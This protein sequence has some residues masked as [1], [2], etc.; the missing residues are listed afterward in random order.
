MEQS[1][2]LD[3]RDNPPP[4]EICLPANY[5]FLEIMGKGCYGVVAKC[6]KEDSKETVAV[7]VS[8]YTENAKTE[9]VM[10]QNLMSQGLDEHNIVRFHESF[11]TDE[12]N[13]LVFE[14]LDMSLHDYMI[15]RMAPAPLEGIRTVIQQLATALNALRNI[16]VI[17][18][19]IKLDNI[20]LVDHRR[21][22]FRVKLIDFGLAIPRSEARQGVQYQPCYCRSPEIILGA[23]F[24]EAID[25]WSLGCVMAAMLGVVL[26]PGRCEYDL[27]RDMVDLFG[28]PTDDFLD[29]GLKSEKFFVKLSGSQW[30]LKLCKGTGS[31]HRDHTFH[32]LDALKMMNLDNEDHA[33]V[34]DRSECIELLKGMLKMDP[35]ERITPSEVLRHPFITKSHLNGIPHSFA[36][37]F[38]STSSSEDIV[39]SASEDIWMSIEDIFESSDR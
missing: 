38:W 15:N 20:M 23:P 17:H 6:F 22:P 21:Q 30:S 34:A 10:L 36:E 27:M 7:K 29:A 18:T 8:R 19:D 9:V 13:A 1:D 28:Q 5:K 14:I 4:N 25:M 33:E 12:G 26:F 31:Y 39:D 11:E 35:R 16:G 2:I 3:H 32:S 24:S 37:F